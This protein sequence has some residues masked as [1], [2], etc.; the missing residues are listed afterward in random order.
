MGPLGIKV[1]IIETGGSR[2][3]FAGS[4]SELSEGRSEYDSTVGASVRFQ[5]N[6]NGKQPRDPGEGSGSA[7]LQDCSRVVG[8]RK[9]PLCIHWLHMIFNLWRN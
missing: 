7:L 9:Y 5:R 8:H 1:T 3:G 4:S 6:Y 2:T